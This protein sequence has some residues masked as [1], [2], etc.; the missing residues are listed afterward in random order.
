MNTKVNGPVIGIDLGTTN[1][2]V[3]VMEGKTA[4]VIE[5][6]EGAR[7]TP[8]V[9]AFTKHGERLIGL[10]A[11]RQAVVNAQNTV[12]AFKRL[13]GRQFRDKEVQDDIKHWPFK[14][15]PKSEGHPAV[16]VESAGK[17]ESFTAEQLSSMVLT[18][19]RETA[20]NFLSKKVN[21]AVVTV[22]AYFNDAQRQATKDA[23]QIAGLDVLRVINEPTAACLA[24]GADKHNS[25]VVA[26]YD[27]GGGTFDI[28]ILEMQNGVFEVK[29]TNG[30]THL[31]GEDFDIALVNYLLEEFKKEHGIDLNNDRMAIQRIREAAEKAKIELSSATQTDINLPYITAD[32]T[33]A[34]NMFVPLSR[35]KLE[36]LV[37]PLI[38]RTVEPCRKA[39]NDA[40]VKSN[41][42]EEIILVGGM[43]RMPRVIETVKTIFGRE[44]SKGVNPDEAVAIGAAIQGGVLTGHVTDILLLDVTPLSLGIETLGG[45]MTKLIN[46]NTTIPTKK[47][48]V[49]STAADG[50]TA[51]EVKIYQGERE[52]VRDNKLLGN[53][54]LVGI[55]PAPKGVPQIEITFDIDA[56]GIVNVSAKDKATGKDQSMTIASSSGLSENDIQK[57]VDD[58]EQYA[59]TDKARRALIE[60]ANK[61]DSVCA[62]TE[63]ALN[64]FKDQVDPTEKEKVSK[65]VEELRELAKKGQS[66]DSSVTADTIR[67]KISETQTS[68]LGL[69]QKIYE[70]RNAEEAAKDASKEEEST[71]K[72]D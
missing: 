37:A 4:R 9:V 47:S 25:A 1:S 50:Q 49:F 34:K 58:A 29:S 15:V 13:I 42:I 3:A 28:S 30:D 61:A 19:M 63:K 6:A 12:F 11:K 24:Y 70:K 2:C 67:D 31:G 71:E 38:Q 41:E 14:V 8:S 22:P 23:G 40:G 17:K 48:Q 59:E 72:K 55:P 62:D 27:L 36:S 64:E 20:E 5:N 16:E 66:G 7:T 65:L 69:F 18:K 43:S 10:P 68:S 53:F 21:H 60:E 46:R 52:L 54:N 45:I 26:V 35:S 51:I 33:G 56:D 44:P 32:A 57:M 39:L